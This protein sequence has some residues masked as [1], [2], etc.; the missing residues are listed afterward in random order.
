M[1]LKSGSDAA[2]LDQFQKAAFDYFV[3]YANPENGLV[4][5]T[6]QPGAPCSIA[7]TG[8]G[9]SCYP[10]GVER[11][12]MSREDGAARTLATL[13]FFASSEQ[14]RHKE[15]TGYKGLYYHFLD[16]QTGKRVWKSELSLIDSALLIAGMLTAAAYFTENN[17]TE[18]EIRSHAAMLYARANWAWALDGKGALWLGWKPRSGFLPYH[19]EGYS[20]ALIL[21]V[22]ALSSPSYPVGFESYEAF[23]AKFNWMTLRDTPYLYAGPLFIHLFSHAWIDFRGIRDAAVAAYDTDY[24]ENTRHAIAIQRDYATRNPGGFSGYGAD[25]WGLTS[26]DGPVRPRRLLDGRMQAFSGYAARGAPLGPDD[27]TVAP[28]APMACI[29]FEPEAA[30][31]ATRNIVSSYPGVMKDGRFLGSFNPSIPAK[32]TEGWVD[33]RCVGLDQGLVAMMIENHRSGL[34][35]AL[36]RDAPAIRRGL[37]RAGFSGGWL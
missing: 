24:F 15:A 21:Y 2:I 14:S 8:F 5:D 20:E 35:W 25:M 7:A 23:T 31:N 36:L 9:L 26:C 37:T 12:W 22:L 11:G 27:G 10:I 32:G 18:T 28:W 30:A 4:A 13:R 1:L 33:D 34:I 6:S 17:D 19:W 29:A 3:I 16:M